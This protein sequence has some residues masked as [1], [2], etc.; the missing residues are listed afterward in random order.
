L[1]QQAGTGIAL[2]LGV[3]TVGPQQVLWQGDVRP[4]CATRQIDA[5]QQAAG[6]DDF[7]IGS[8]FPA[9]SFCRASLALVQPSMSGDNTLKQSEARSR[10]AGLKTT[11]IVSL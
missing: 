4:H 7:G 6:L 9:F 11:V 5:D 8:G 2:V 10:M 3:A 1:G